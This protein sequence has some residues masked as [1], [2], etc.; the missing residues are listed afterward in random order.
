MA[1]NTPD[2]MPYLPGNNV[3]I[4]GD[5]VRLRDFFTALA[6]GGQVTLPMEKQMWGAEFGQLTDKF[7]INWMVNLNA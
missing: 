1:S 2:E 4:S 3:T 5:D 7:G 6:E